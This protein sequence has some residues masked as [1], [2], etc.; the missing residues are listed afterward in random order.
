[1]IRA[2]SGLILAIRIIERSS[3]ATIGLI[4]SLTR[5]SDVRRAKGAHMTSATLFVEYIYIYRALPYMVSARFY[6]SSYV[7]N[8]LRSPF[9]YESEGNHSMTVVPYRQQVFDILDLH[10][11][12]WS[13]VVMTGLDMDSECALR[14]DYGRQKASCASLSAE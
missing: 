5:F 8:R 7:D 6:A 2:R 3:F 11:V 13:Y 4:T 9:A 10:I 12:G 14:I 1:M